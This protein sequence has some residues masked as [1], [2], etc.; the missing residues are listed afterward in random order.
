MFRSGSG[1]GQAEWAAT[2]RADHMLN[3]HPT[4]FELH[5]C[6]SRY[7]DGASPHALFDELS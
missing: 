4:I 7:L 5:A 1:S 2:G 3:Y 6:A